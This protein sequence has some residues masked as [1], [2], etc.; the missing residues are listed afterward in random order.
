MP[1]TPSS[2]LGRCLRLLILPLVAALVWT[3]VVAEPALA[4]HNRSRPFSIVD[5]TQ[6][7]VGVPDR[8]RCSNDRAISDY[9]C[10]NDDVGFRQPLISRVNQPPGMLTQN[11]GVDENATKLISPD[12]FRCTRSSG[13][14]GA[15][16]PGEWSCRAGNTRFTLKDIA[17]A[18]DENDPS[19]EY[20]LPCVPCVKQP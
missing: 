7:L 5:D 12:S 11:Y 13:A 20:G 9:V 15:G 19:I 6:P 4:R 16:L 10:V 1:Y 2:T 18:Q 3:T 8:I 14:G 17:Y